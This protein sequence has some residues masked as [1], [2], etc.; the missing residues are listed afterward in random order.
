MYSGVLYRIHRVRGR[1]RARWNQ[2]RTW[3]PL[4]DARW[5]PHPDPVGDHQ[6]D[7]V[8]YTAGDYTTAFA[9]AFQQTRA[10]TL[11]DAKALTAWTPLRELRL[12][13]LTGMW[14]LRNGASGSLDSAPRSTCRMWARAIRAAWPELDGLFTQSTMTKQPVVTLF[15]PAHD[16]FPDRP[17]VARGLGHRAIGPLAVDAADQLGWPIR[18]V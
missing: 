3:G 11:N 2:M 12:L 15:A 17:S 4:S 9:E 1:Y 13:D 14:A 8:L 5:D 10:I 7:A 6:A 18:R 16:S